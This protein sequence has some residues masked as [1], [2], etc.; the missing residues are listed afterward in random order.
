MAELMLKARLGLGE[1][2]RRRRLLL[3]IHQ[4]TMRHGEAGRRALG[5]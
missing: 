3:P 4:Q 5:A 2:E 1:R